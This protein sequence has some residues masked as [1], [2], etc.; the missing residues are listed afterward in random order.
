[1]ARSSSRPGHHRGASKAKEEARPQVRVGQRRWCLLRRGGDGRG[2][3][4]GRAKTSAKK[5]DGERKKS[6]KE[7]EDEE[8]SVQVQE[9]QEEDKQ[10]QTEDSSDGEGDDDDDES[11][12]KA[13][14]RRRGR[15]KEPSRRMRTRTTTNR[16]PSPRRRRRR[17]D[18]RKGEAEKKAKKKKTEPAPKKAKP[19]TEAHPSRVPPDKR[20]RVRDSVNTVDLPT[21]DQIRARNA[22]CLAVSVCRR[23][24][25]GAARCRRHVGVQLIPYVRQEQSSAGKPVTRVTYAMAAD[26]VHPTDGQCHPGPAASPDGRGRKDPAARAGHDCRRGGRGRTCAHQDDNGRARPLL[27]PL[28]IDVFDVEAGTEPFAVDFTAGWTKITRRASAS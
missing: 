28:R 19:S 17:R 23:N 9:D 11:A 10:R 26:A 27:G 13:S 15:L 4:Q 8:G 14:G 12:A 1:M 7:D 18:Q 2:R 6:V 22:Y 25:K 16:L 21:E 20:K 3:T 5:E 24:S